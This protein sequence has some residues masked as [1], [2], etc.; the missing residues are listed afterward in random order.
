M[1]RGSTS[2]R[3]SDPAVR[4]DATARGPL[5]RQ[6]ARTRWSRGAGSAGD[7][8]DATC[9]A[10]QP[11][12]LQ[13]P[14]DGGCGDAGIDELPA[15]EQ[16]EL[17]L[18]RADGGGGQAH[19]VVLGRGLGPEHRAV[20]GA[21]GERGR[22]RGGGC[23]GRGGGG[24]RVSD[25]GA[26]GSG[27]QGSGHPARRRND[28]EVWRRPPPTF[29]RT[30]TSLGDV[31]VRIFAG[32]AWAGVGARGPGWW[33]VAGRGVGAER[34]LRGGRWRRG[35]PGAWPGSRP[36]RCRD[37]SRPPR[38]PRPAP[39]PSVPR[40][41][42]SGSPPPTP[43]CPGGRPSPPDRRRRPRSRPSCRAMSPSAASRGASAHRRRRVQH[44]HQLDDRR[45]RCRQPP[46]QPGGQVLD[47]GHGHDGRLGL[48]VEVRAVRQQRLV[49]QVDGVAVLDP[50]LLRGHQGG[51][52]AGVGGRV[53]PPGRGAGHRVAAHDVAGAGHQQLGAGP[54]EAPHAEPQAV[55]EGRPQPPQHRTH[56]DV[57]I[58]GDRHLPGQHDLVGGAGGE[59]VAGGGHR[60]A[61]VLGWAG[62]A[63]LEGA[64]SSG[65]VGGEA[66][67]LGD[68]GRPG[69]VG[70]HLVEGGVVVGGPRALV[71]HGGGPPGAVLGPADHDARHRQVR[72]GR[73]VERPGPEGHGAGAGQVEGILDGDLAQDPAHGGR[74]SGRVP[75][76]VGHQG[77]GEGVAPPGEGHPAG[78]PQHAVVA[79]HRHEVGIG[80][81]PSGHR[82]PPGRTVVLVRRGVAR[83]GRAAPL[84]A[85]PARH[86][87]HQPGLA[88]VAVT[89]WAMPVDSRSRRTST[90]PASATMATSS[91]GGGR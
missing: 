74:R 36:A 19:V 83:P 66:G 75:A 18:G 73:R 16:A 63:Q 48:L 51:G 43:R 79:G 11:P 30:G 8:V 34:R 90:K 56:G 14:I 72:P 15:G 40:S 59:G 4:W 17:L 2:N 13:P 89:S 67:Q 6:A 41:G 12:L 77:D 71:Q 28:G 78:V 23:R 84:A 25:P 87:A 65:L 86:R 68:A 57:G 22:G 35:G 61:P 33:R 20:R 32:G 70:Q 85:V 44:A 55:G 58:G 80:V 60:G 38:P 62:R 1:P 82:P 7:P 46:L 10:R 39:G 5:A 3:L 42:P 50:V 47:V 54:H 49:D 91:S 88:R 45:R 31:P 21:A 52:Q 37:P 69:G 76:D 64:R 9:G 53:P 24:A 26:I 81:Q 27:A 29:W